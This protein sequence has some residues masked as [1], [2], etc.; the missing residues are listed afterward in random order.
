MAGRRFGWINW[1]LIGA[2][3]EEDVDDL[4]YDYEWVEPEPGTV[5]VCWSLLFVPSE[6]IH[7]YSRE[8]VASE[9]IQ[10]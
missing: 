6:I 1:D 8:F 10:F 4:N 5:I 9:L 7:Q 3:A 2:E